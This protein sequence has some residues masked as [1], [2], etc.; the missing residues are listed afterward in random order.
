MRSDRLWFRKLYGDNICTAQE[1][2]PLPS[3]LDEEH[4]DYHPPPYIGGDKDTETTHCTQC[5]ICL[6]N[7]ET[8]EF[9]ATADE[10]YKVVACRLS[11]LDQCRDDC[12]EDC[13]HPTIANV[14]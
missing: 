3:V 14:M 11:F 10:L 9:L 7:C 5:K 8:A 1:L 2:L 12:L 13:R 6:N 4:V